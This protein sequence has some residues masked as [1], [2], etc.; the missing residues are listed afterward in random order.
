[1]VECAT[2]VPVLAEYA[3]ELVTSLLHDDDENIELW[4]IMGVAALS[5]QP[6]DTEG[7]R[8]HLDTAKTM[9]ETLLENMTEQ[10]STVCLPL[11]SIVG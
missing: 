4:Y 7:A 9:M 1:M 3:M 2:V 10:V 6:P 5:C 11:A 8:Y